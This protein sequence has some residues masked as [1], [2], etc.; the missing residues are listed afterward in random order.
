MEEIRKQ[1]RKRVRKKSKS[2]ASRDDQKDSGANNSNVVI[3][4]DSSMPGSGSGSIPTALIIVALVFVL[5]HFSTF[6]FAPVRPDGPVSRP[7]WFSACPSS[8]YS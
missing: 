3:D 6:G 8:S 1:R 4:G 7:W 5:S 2:T